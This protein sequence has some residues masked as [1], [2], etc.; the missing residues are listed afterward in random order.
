MPAAA[1]GTWAMSW[2][3]RRSRSSGSTA[4]ARWRELGA[5]E[6]ALNSMGDGREY[7]ASSS[8]LCRAKPKS[9]EAR[10]GSSGVTV[11]PAS[12]LPVE[13]RTSFSSPSSSS[14]AIWSWPCRE[15]GGVSSASEHRVEADWWYCAWCGVPRRMCCR[16]LP[17]LKHLPKQPPRV[18]HRSTRVVCTACRL[19]Q[20]RSQTRK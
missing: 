4:R 18:W 16:R 3:T 7:S 13:E 10:D 6:G 20:G 1:G 5:I 11:P 12:R 19:G 17:M 9:S 8:M 15:G 14:S 2:R